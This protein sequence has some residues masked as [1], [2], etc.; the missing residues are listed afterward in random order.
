M[1]GAGGRPEPAAPPSHW[2]WRVHRGTSRGVL[3]LYPPPPHGAQ[4][5]RVDSNRPLW[6]I[7][8]ARR[9]HHSAPDTYKR[10]VKDGLGA[11]VS[12]TPLA[13]V[14]KVCSSR[15]MHNC[16]SSPATTLPC[17]TA[18]TWFTFRTDFSR[19]SSSLRP[20][21]LAD[22]AL[23]VVQSQSLTGGMQGAGTVRRDWRGLPPLTCHTGNHK[24]G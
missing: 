12:S 9:R 20:Q 16:C 5:A 10:D 24:L 14:S 22:D 1:P 21:L 6:S 7:S 2:T 19:L 4:R 23:S 13:A 17:V 8:A 3:P 11:R 15:P 18:A